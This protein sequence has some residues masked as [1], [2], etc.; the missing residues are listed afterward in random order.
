MRVKVNIILL[1][2]LICVSGGVVSY[3]VYNNMGNIQEEV[4]LKDILRKTEKEL[5]SLRAQLVVLK[6]QLEDKE[7]QIESLVSRN[8]ERDKE[9]EKFKKLRDKDRNKVGDLL[10]QIEY[11]EKEISQLK[12]E[13][14]IFRDEK[15]KISKSLS[16]LKEELRLRSGDIKSLNEAQ[17]SRQFN[18]NALRKIRQK[19]VKLRIEAQEKIDEMKRRV[20][21]GG[22]LIKDGKSTLNRQSIIELEKI[23]IEYNKGY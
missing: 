16:A 18:I 11:L 17:I 19:V 4:R 7:S 20:G 23:I 3:F 2:I 8:N 21:N 15:D 14:A 9:I 22:Y 5:E 12:R 1:I 13:N 6:K 10:S